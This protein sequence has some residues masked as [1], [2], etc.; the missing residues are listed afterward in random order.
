MTPGKLYLYNRP[1]TQKGYLI[2]GP[3]HLDMYHVPAYGALSPPTAGY[4]F[5]RP[6]AAV[7]FLG[8]AINKERRD[9]DR[10][11]FLVGTKILFC[12]QEYK[13]H[14]WFRPTKGG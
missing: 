4:Y 2:G 7:L 6:G 3:G 11:Y 14:R 12:Y 13:I 5:I 1:T 8:R 10:Y 9:L